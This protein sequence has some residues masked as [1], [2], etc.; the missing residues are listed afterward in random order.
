MKFLTALSDKIEIGH[1]P[2]NVPLS[3]ALPNHHDYTSLLDE[4]A[5]YIIL[6]CFE[7]ND[8]LLDLKE[9]AEQIFVAYSAHSSEASVICLVPFGHLTF[10]ALAGIDR[11]EDFMEKLHRLLL[12][13]GLK[14]KRVPVG[15][16][17][18]FFARFLFFD[19]LHATKLRSSE[20]SL[21]EVLTSLLRAF[22]PDKLMKTIA[23]VLQHNNSK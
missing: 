11:A 23:H 20:N 12:N 1:L 18:L 22:G 7:E 10:T 21:R 13:K 16:G 17:N 2:D 14:V 9:A 6:A 3:K 19:K 5:A 15:K 8:S 4:K